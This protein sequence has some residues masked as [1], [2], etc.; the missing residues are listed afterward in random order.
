VI[1]RNRQLPVNK[2][3]RGTPTHAGGVDFEGDLL[4]LGLDDTGVVDLVVAVAA[5]LAGEGGHQHVLEQ[6]DAREQQP[7]FALPSELPCVRT[8]AQSHM[9]TDKNCVNKIVTCRRI[10]ALS[11]RERGKEDARKQAS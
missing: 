2:H 11:T 6:W 9:K 3:V 8:H 10:R 5:V 1:Q 7:R 4:A